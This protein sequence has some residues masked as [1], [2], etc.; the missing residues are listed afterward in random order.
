MTSFVALLLSNVLILVRICAKNGLLIAKRLFLA[1][2]LARIGAIS[3]VLGGEV[4]LGVPSPPGLWESRLWTG[5]KSASEG[6]CQEGR[7]KTP[8]CLFTLIS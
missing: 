8:T 1:P 4:D 2:I 3:L 7:Q 6:G 5:L